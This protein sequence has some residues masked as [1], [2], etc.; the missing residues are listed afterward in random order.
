MTRSKSGSE[1]KPSR[2]RKEAE[3]SDAVQ[4]E[5]IEKRRRTARAGKSLQ[6]KGATAQG[7]EP[8]G[9]D[10]QVSADSDTAVDS[11]ADDADDDGHQTCTACSSSSC[12]SCSNCS[13]CSSCSCRSDS[14]TV[15]DTEATDAEVD[16]DAKD[17]HPQASA[18]AASGAQ[19]AEDKIAEK[20]W[21]PFEPEDVEGVKNLLALPRNQTANQI[22]GH[23]NDRAEINDHEAAEALLDISHNRHEDQT[24][25]RSDDR[26]RTVRKIRLRINPA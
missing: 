7:M 19:T 1:L 25:T 11:D 8:T 13:S 20:T 24:W 22:W 26:P 10:F 16:P 17:V 6:K 4:A 5:N 21:L 18:H 15:L 12:C 14:D 3:D 9:A 2:K 23:L